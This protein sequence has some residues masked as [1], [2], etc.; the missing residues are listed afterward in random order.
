MHIFKICIYSWL[1]FCRSHLYKKL[2]PLFDV[3]KK[4]KVQQKYI[5][6]L[7][8]LLVWWGSDWANS[9][10]KY[11]TIVMALNS[12]G[13]KWQTNPIKPVL[14]CWWCCNS[15]K[16]KAR[17]GWIYKSSIYYV[18]CLTQIDFPLFMVFRLFSKYLYGTSFKLTLSVTLKSPQ[19]LK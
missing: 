2:L 1:W 7:C 15:C 16:V 13:F 6:V 5:T 11:K 14:F 19:R 17:I 10:V 12:P 4:T 3:A 9:E 18:F 8:K